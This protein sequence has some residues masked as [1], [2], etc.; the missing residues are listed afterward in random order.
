[1]VSEYGYDKLGL[2][3]SVPLS[4][5]S[6]VVVVVL[7]VSVCRLSKATTS[8]NDVRSVCACAST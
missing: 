1:M 2:Y 3:I 4:I 8:V 5:M 6:V 7:S